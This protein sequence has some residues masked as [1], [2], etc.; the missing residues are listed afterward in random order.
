MLY[1]LGG[2]SGEKNP[3]GRLIDEE[4]ATWNSNM[5][6]V[7]ANTDFSI[8]TGRFSDGWREKEGGKYMWVAPVTVSI[9]HDFYLYQKGRVVRSIIR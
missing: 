1:M 4:A 6:V 5:R 3:R 8:K 7:R 2:S 9:I